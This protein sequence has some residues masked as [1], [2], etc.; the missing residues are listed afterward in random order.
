MQKIIEFLGIEE[1][2]V[3]DP[4]NQEAIQEATEVRKKYEQK[5]ATGE[6]FYA[7]HEDV[8]RFYDSDE[9]AEIIERL[10]HISVFKIRKG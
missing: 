10:N 6:V 3:N 5:L 2:F 8:F 9:K 1:E 4:V 7:F